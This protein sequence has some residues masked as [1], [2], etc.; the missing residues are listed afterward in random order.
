MIISMPNGDVANGINKMCE[1]GICLFE[2]SR[3]LALCFHRNLCPEG[4]ETRLYL[5]LA[6]GPAQRRGQNYH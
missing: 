6:N 2:R 3:R 1:V 5:Q 4:Y